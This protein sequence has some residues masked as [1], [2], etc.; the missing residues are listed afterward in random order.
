MD[1]TIRDYIKDRV[2]WCLA[3]GIAGWLAAASDFFWRNQM[4][5]PIVSAAGIIM[6]GGAILAVQWI[7]CPKCSTKLGQIA[8]SLAVPGLRPKPNFCPYCGVSLDE[9]CNQASAARPYNPIN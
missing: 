1:G 3:I 8:M 4:L 7:K 9:P 5:T 6:F 2:R